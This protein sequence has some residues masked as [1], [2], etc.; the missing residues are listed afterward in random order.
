[1]AQH[2]VLRDGLSDGCERLARAP[3]AVRPRS[4]SAVAR[5]DGSCG[6]FIH[7]GEK[8]F[9][10]SAA[11]SRRRLRSAAATTSLSSTPKA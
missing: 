10:R 9:R 4:P 7:A 2:V 6:N 8:S 5:R 3:F 1:M 11:S